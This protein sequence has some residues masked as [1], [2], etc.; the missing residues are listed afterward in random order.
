MNSV[1]EGLLTPSTFAQ[2]E[3]YRNALLGFRSTVRNIGGADGAA[4]SAYLDGSLSLLSMQD[5]SQDG[6]ALLE[7]IDPTFVVCENG[8]P[9]SQA[10]ERFQEAKNDSQEAYEFFT[11]VQQNPSIGNALGA[12][13]V[14]NVVQT[15]SIL[16]EVN[17][18]RVE[19]LKSACGFSV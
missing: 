9:A 2:R 8:T 11:R 16:I 12:D 17:T 15:T 1:P 14:V 5:S 4:L 6:L 18:E 7:N 19:Q 3:S 10:I 13:Y